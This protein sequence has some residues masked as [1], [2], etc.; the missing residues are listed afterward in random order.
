M[1][2]SCVGA[3]KGGLLVLLFVGLA[4]CDAPRN[5]TGIGGFGN[6]ANQIFAGGVGDELAAALAAEPTTPKVTDEMLVAIYAA[7]LERAESGDPE[8]ALV[9]LKVADAQRRA[10]ASED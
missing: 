10:A 4:G 2:R 6:S 5:G 1:K 9:I 8:A 3:F 7:I